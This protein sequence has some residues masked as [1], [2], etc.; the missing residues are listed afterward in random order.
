MYKFIF[1]TNKSY[2]QG[3]SLNANGY[4]I[5]INKSYYTDKDYTG[6][7]VSDKSAFVIV[8]MTVKNTQQQRE[9]DLQKY[10]VM[11]GIKDYVTTEKIYETEFQDFG[12]AVKT[13]DLKR[14]ESQTFI[15]IFKVDKELRRNRFVLYYQEFNGDTPHLR[16]IKLK[17]NDVS[18]IK[19]HKA[20][21]IGDELKFTLE[22]KTEKITFD[23]F[24]FLDSIEY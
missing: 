19:E 12:N 15:M 18:E 5:T 23:D 10:H 2:G 8:N 14:D 1:I 3:E 20:I 9:A 21:T 13:L 17:L 6:K 4:E 22:E 7:V 24:E 11:N 16:K